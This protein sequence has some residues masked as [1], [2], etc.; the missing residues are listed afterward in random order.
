MDELTESLAYDVRWG[1]EMPM[2]NF[3]YHITDWM[4]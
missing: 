3:P 4:L 1:T 2:E